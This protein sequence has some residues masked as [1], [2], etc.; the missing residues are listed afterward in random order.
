MASS[1]A[2][3][4][5][6]AEVSDEVA[7]LCVGDGHHVEKEGLHVEVERLVVQEEL[8]QQAQVLAVL[9]VPAIIWL[10]MWIHQIGS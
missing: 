7:A 1:L 8:G 9:F 10:D 5:L 6:L 4:F 2:G 3:V